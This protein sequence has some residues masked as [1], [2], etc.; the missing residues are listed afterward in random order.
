MTEAKKKGITLQDIGIGVATAMS[1]STMVTVLIDRTTTEAQTAEGLD[2]RVS[3]LETGF[4]AH[5]DKL[6]QRGRFVNE[7]SNQLNFLCATTANC[8]ALYAPIVAPE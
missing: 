3:A 1:I 6:R 7:A 2:R 4:V 5:S 8:R